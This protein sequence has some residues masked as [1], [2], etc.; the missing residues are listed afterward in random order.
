MVK[1]VFRVTVPDELLGA[2]FQAIRDF[3]IKHDPDHEGKVQFESL[4][5]SDWPAKRM[6]EVMSAIAPPPAF[7][8]GA[9]KKP[10][11]GDTCLCIPGCIANGECPIHGDEAV[12]RS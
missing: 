9:K 11:E 2:L 12:G 6:A 5:D 4:V 1:V 7:M 10:D 8:Y 3:D